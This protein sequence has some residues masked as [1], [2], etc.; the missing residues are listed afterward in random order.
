MSPQRG[1]RLVAVPEARFPDKKG[2]PLARDALL[3]EQKFHQAADTGPRPWD[4]LVPATATAAITT[5]TAAAETTT[6]TA[7]AATTT[8]GALFAGTGFIDRHG[9]AVEFL[10]IEL[11]D[12]RIGLFLGAHGHERKSAG[13]AGELVHDEFAGAD[14]ARL[15]DQVEDIAFSGV[16]LQ[17]ADKQLGSHCI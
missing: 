6:A 5:A 14:V 4:R 2:I 9:T 17:I 7:E 11:G 13:L 3:S 12:G 8:A 15:L 1:R 10:A 16:K